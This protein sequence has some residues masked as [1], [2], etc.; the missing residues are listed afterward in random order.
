MDKAELIEQLGALESQIAQDEAAIRELE[1]E[2]EKARRG[3]M[4]GLVGVL[5]GL[6]LLAVV[7]PL[8]LLL[9]LAGILATVTGM[10][11]QSGAKAKL[12]VTQA[13]L[14]ENRGKI[15]QLRAQLL[16]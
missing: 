3:Y 4:S 11:K 9:L 8:G 16:V 15:A 10:I 7:W 5:L 14:A 1:Q 2:A 12:T 13:R 6:I